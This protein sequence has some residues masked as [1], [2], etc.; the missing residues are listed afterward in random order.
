M[1][2][3]ILGL[4]L[5]ALVVRGWLRGLVREVLDLVGLVAGIW[6]AFSLSQPLGDFLSESF[7]VGPEAAR[8]GAGIALFVLF[9]ATLG[10]VAHY[11]SKLMRLPGLNI[12]NRLGGAAVAVGWGV[13]LVLLAA[14]IARAAPLP[15]QWVSSLEDSAVIDTIAGPEAI[16]QRMFR[17]LTGDD[18]MGSLATIRGLFG[19]VRAVPEG[20][21]V[22]EIPP[23]E[24]DELVARGDEAEKVL[25]EIN[26]FRAGR[27][28]GALDSAELL[29]RV[30]E[31]RAWSMY[32]TGRLGR[33][34]PPGA[35]LDEVLETVGARLA[36]RGEAMA[37]AG[38]ALGALDGI[39]DSESG[40]TELSEA[41]YDRVGVA[42]IE[43][44][45]GR[46]LVVVFGG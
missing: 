26:E 30:A 46:L 37:L 33:S 23:A 14:S 16:P 41:N 11:L 45:T 18:V 42:V 3:F 29:T 9:G 24:S 27:G 43:G 31:E 39:L 7:G 35:T 12:A 2:D 10:V 6:I 25:T 36:F 8:I 17:R 5:A 20:D 34:T 38:T 4:F 44:P 22:L 13:L 15:E 1:I 40:L 32:T 19:T 28:L 21:E